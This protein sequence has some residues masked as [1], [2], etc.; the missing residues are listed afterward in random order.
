M[1]EI[2]V[3]V[4]AKP[5]EIEFDL[6][7]LKENLAAELEP[8]KN[9]LV[10]EETVKASKK[11][12]AML[13]A[14][15]KMLND[16]KIEVKKAFTEPYE[17]FEKEVKE[18][19][20]LFDNAISNVDGQVKAFEEKTKE[21]KKAHIRELYDNMITEELAEYLPF[22]KVFVTD[23]LK[24]SVKDKE[25]IDAIEYR[26]SIVRDEIGAIKALNSEIE[27][28]LLLTYKQYGQ[29]AAIKK[30]SD[31]LETKSLAEKRLAEEAQRKAE[32]EK[33][34][35]V[36]RRVAERLAEKEPVA[37]PIVADAPK[38][39]KVTFTVDEND[40]DK[41]REFLRF[42]LIHYTEE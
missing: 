25:V 31:Y 27:A 17:R 35:E 23:W 7:A 1:N 39:G 24:A 21:E 8:Y 20:A 26:M 10:T 15:K 11:D 33:E 3:N 41:V 9:L 4:N 32:A 6:S 16:R 5:G 22:D 36:E 37:E 30:H 18:A 34:A 29:V 12:L 14:N 38:D 19:L 13:R 40:A 2:V 42:S 28:D